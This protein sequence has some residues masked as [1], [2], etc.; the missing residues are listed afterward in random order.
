[1]QAAKDHATECEVRC[2]AAEA[3]AKQA[4]AELL[5]AQQEVA[6]KQEAL[7]TMVTRHDEALSDLRATLEYEMSEAAQASAKVRTPSLAWA[8]MKRPLSALQ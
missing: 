1:V 8:C 6:D 2:S 3:Q 5:R 4:Q 7:E